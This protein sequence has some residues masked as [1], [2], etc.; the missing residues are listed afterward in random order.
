M[1]GERRETRRQ[2]RLIGESTRKPTQ[3][4]IEQNQDSR[5]DCQDRH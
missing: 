3:L 5:S 2:E 1:R 4:S